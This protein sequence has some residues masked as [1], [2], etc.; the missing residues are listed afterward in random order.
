MSRKAFLSMFA[1]IILAS[2]G[3]AQSRWVNPN[4]TI[5]AVKVDIARI[6]ANSTA[7]ESA[8]VI[9]EGRAYDVEYR[10]MKKPYTEIPYTV[11]KVADM[12]GNYINIF[13]ISH[14]PVA[15]GDFVKV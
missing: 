2:L 11:F 8:G 3:C 1:V 6:L 4:T 9:V 12:D 15:Q 7:Y 13:A 5:P 10:I 14:F